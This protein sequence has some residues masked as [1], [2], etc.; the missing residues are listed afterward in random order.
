MLQK[1]II[2]IIELFIYFKNLET[3]FSDLYTNIQYYIRKAIQSNRQL[4]NK[5][6]KQKTAEIA[7]TC[8]KTTLLSLLLGYILEVVKEILTQHHCVHNSQDLR[9]GYQ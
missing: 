8:V 7:N 6:Y 1:N 4:E 3:L 9:C 2:H 5:R